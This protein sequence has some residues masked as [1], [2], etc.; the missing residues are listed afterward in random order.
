VHDDAPGGLVAY[1]FGFGDRLVLGGTFDAGRDD[2]QTDAPALDAIIERC[3]ELLR[4]DG[5]P[6]WAD[7]AKTR[8]RVIAG[9]RP[10]R[11]LGNEYELTRVERDRLP[12][13]RAIIHN[14]GHGRAGVTLSWATAEDAAEL[15]LEAMT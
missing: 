1:V 8:S 12:D 15:A 9:V 6:R 5:F 2:A 4:L 10:T 13:G 3:R 14:Y 7:L 11:G